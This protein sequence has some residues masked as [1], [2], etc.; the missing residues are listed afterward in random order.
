MVL[1]NDVQD[2]VMGVQWYNSI[3]SGSPDAHI[4]IL[5]AKIRG[6]TYGNPIEFGQDLA[7]DDDLLENSNIG[8]FPDRILIWKLG[9]PVTIIRIFLTWVV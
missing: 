3:L 1:D 4:E 7:P 6:L 9:N 5:D 8:C 2:I